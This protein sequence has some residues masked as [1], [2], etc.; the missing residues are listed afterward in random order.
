MDADDYFLVVLVYAE[1]GRDLGVSLPKI[2]FLTT[3][4]LLMRPVGAVIFGAPSYDV[5][6]VLHLLHGIGM[7]G[8]QCFGCRCSHCSCVG[9]YAH[10]VRFGTG[11]ATPLPT[12]QPVRTG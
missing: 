10:G 4:T 5:L 1:V 6:L 11:D 9:K 12:P 3:A 7:G 8:E 2:A